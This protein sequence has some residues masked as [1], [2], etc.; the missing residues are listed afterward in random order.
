MK[1]DMFNMQLEESRV[2]NKI[3]DMSA[4]VKEL[5]ALNN[6]SDEICRKIASEFEKDYISVK[7][8]LLPQDLKRYA[9]MSISELH[10]IGESTYKKL[11]RKYSKYVGNS[12]SKVGTMTNIMNGVIEK[13]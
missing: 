6:S 4:R 13:K 8:Y 5:R 3:H 10:D 12:A 7:K 9:G 1:L 11:I 2:N